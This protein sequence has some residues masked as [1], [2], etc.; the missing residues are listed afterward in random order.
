M[1]SINEF[2]LHNV[3]KTLHWYGFLLLHWHGSTNEYFSRKIFVY[4]RSFLGMM[5]KLDKYF[6][7]S[8]ILVRDFF[9]CLLHY[10]NN[11]RKM[12]KKTT[13]FKNYLSKVSFQVKKKLKQAIIMCFYNDSA[14]NLN[15]QRI[16]ENEQSES[17]PFQLGIYS[18]D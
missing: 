15:G 12:L 6:C 13:S 1:H 7:Y 16:R 9:C 10:K 18:T 11:K 4:L 5:P 3:I 2:I 14:V 17:V 8:Y